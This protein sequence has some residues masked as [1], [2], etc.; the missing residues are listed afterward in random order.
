MDQ[1]PLPFALVDTEDNKT[2]DTE[3][4][5]KTWCTTNCFR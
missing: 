2:C 1:T 4:P 5:N 3:R